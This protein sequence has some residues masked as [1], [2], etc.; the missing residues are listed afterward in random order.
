MSPLPEPHLHW[1]EHYVRYGFALIK[2]VVGPEFMAPALAE[3][4]ALLGT[5]LP[6]A[7]WTK[8]AG[9]T[10][11]I[12]YK[13]NN[14]TVLP[15]IYDQPKIKEII[16]TV[17]GG[18]E[19]WSGE[20]MFQLFTNAWNEEAKPE[21]SQQCHIDFVDCP[22]PILGSGLAFQVSLVKSEPFSGNLTLLPG[23]H[24]PV[25]RALIG[26]PD[27]TY[28]TDLQQFLDGPPW[29]F[30]A[31]PGDMVLFHHLVGHN[32]NVSHAAGRTP[33]VAI[34]GHILRDTWLQEVD[35]ANPALSPWERSMAQN[36]P[37]RVIRDELAHITAMKAQRRSQPAR[38]RAY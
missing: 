24:I 35:P 21:L 7:Q 2:G 29:E 9:H 19:R 26:N 3:A 25:Q 20:R 34:H 22:I 27:L 18:W 33:R 8:A 17:L 13:N 38:A 23:S 10:Q 32:G 5:D 30:V 12:S 28:P 31:D 16:G 4:A 6:P 37:Y 36:G 11:H 14:M 15:T 1:T